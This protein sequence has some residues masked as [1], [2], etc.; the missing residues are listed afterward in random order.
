M[1]EHVSKLFRDSFNV[2]LELISAGRLAG[3]LIRSIGRGRDYEDL[4]P[5][6]FTPP[7]PRAIAQHNDVDEA[8]KNITIPAVPWCSQSL[9]TKD[10][11]GNEF[12]IWL[13]HQSEQEH[14]RI[15]CHVDTNMKPSD[16]ADY[17]VT[18]DQSLDMD[19]AWGAGGK[20]T[21]RGDGP[22]SMPE[23]GEAMLTGKWPRKAGL[24]VAD[25]EHQWQLTLQADRLTVSAIKLPTVEDLQ[26]PRELIESRIMMIDSLAKSLDRLYATFLSR[27]IGS[28]WPA[29][30]STIASW[31]K[32]RRQRPGR[33][34]VDNEHEL[35]AVGCEK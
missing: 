27:R 13:W 25:N 17:Y 31:I 33:V 23:A 10:Y 20:Q 16:T 8:A 3:D 26:S 12:M 21:L 15:D 9:D 4:Q 32:K 19:C 14:G 11:L 5:S 1:I 28:T 35:Q 6:P 7:P 22:V 2:E 18:F 24:I 34:R 29:S 30:R